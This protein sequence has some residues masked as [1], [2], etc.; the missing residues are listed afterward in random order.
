MKQKKAH[1]R[2][3]QQIPVLAQLSE[4]QTNDPEV[5]SSNLTGDNF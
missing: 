3:L 2:N 4:H 5:V 1:F